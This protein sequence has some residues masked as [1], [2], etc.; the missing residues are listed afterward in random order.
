M[1]KIYKLDRDVSE[2]KSDQLTLVVQQLV[3]ATQDNDAFKE[4]ICSEIDT[5]KVNESNNCHGKDNK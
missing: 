1:M 4:S 2:K 3:T 5:L